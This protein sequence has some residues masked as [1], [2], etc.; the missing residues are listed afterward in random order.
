V[1]IISYGNGLFLSL[2]AARRLQADG[3]P[4]RVAD[5]R[6][7]A[8]LDLELCLSEAKA[9][10]RVLVVDECRRTGSPS[11]QIVTALVEAGFTGAIARVTAEDTY[12]PLG[13]AANLV[14]PSEEGIVAA[15]RSL[16]RL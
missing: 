11:E 14:L 6:W 16:A 3:I 8:P 12:V 5:L 9:T 10:G 7:L 13:P 2:R 1:S 15:A 4:A